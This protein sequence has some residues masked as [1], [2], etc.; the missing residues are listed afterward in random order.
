MVTSSSTCLIPQS[1]P[2]IRRSIDAPASSFGAVNFVTRNRKGSFHLDIRK[3]IVSFY[4]NVVKHAP[5]DKKD[6][7][8]KL[9]RK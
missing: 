1:Q 2:W 3:L 6:I 8:S 4:C 7:D 9:H 5:V